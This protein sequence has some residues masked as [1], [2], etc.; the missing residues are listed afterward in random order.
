MITGD[1][2]TFQCISI[3]DDA[4][5][6]DGM[7][8]GLLWKYVE[9]REDFS[10]IE[11]Y[12][13]PGRIPTIFTIREM[14]HDVFKSVLK[15]PTEV[16]RLEAAL[17][18]GLVTVSGLRSDDGRILNDPPLGRYP[19]GVLRDEE[20][21]RIAD[22]EQILE[23]GEV[24]FTRSFFARRIVRVYQLPRLLLERW[25]HLVAHRVAQ[26]LA[27]QGRNSSAASPGESAATA[28][29]NGTASPTQTPGSSSDA[30]TAATAADRSQAAA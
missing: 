27:L 13:I 9:N 19:N 1:D 11:P 17:Q 8:A 12:L 22:W 21:K 10:L 7:P 4:L 16:D 25:E 20:M 2:N 6:V 15:Q 26:S 28:P 3:G 23:I 29:S 24:A 18:G 5:D 14:P 30:S